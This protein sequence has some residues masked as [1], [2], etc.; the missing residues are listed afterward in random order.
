MEP[1]RKTYWITKYLFTCGI[2]QKKLACPLILTMSAMDGSFIELVAMRTKPRTPPSPAKK[3]IAKKARQ[4]RQAAV[5]ATEDGG[6]TVMRE[7][8]ILMSGPLVR[9]TL[10]GLE[11]TDQATDQ[12]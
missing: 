12:A 6:G 5:Q 10:A 9:A 11:D 2:E 1:E 7:I 3:M 4:S 8:P